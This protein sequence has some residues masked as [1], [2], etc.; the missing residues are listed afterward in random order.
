[1][2]IFLFE[3]IQ[4]GLKAVVATD[5]FQFFLIMGGMLAI[6]VRGASLAGGVGQVFQT[7]YDTGRLNFF[8]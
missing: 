5:C 2:T 7:A 3:F 4:G 6:I 1:M 8:E